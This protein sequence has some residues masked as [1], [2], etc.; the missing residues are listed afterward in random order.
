VGTTLADLVN[1][2]LPLFLRS[3]ALEPDEGPVVAGADSG[4]K[5]FGG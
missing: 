2:G 1:N 4:P 3:L 5:P